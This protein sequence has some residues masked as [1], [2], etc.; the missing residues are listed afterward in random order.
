MKKKYCGIKTKDYKDIITSIG[1]VTPESQMKIDRQE[2][3]TVLNRGQNHLKEL[4]IQKWL[5][6]RKACNPF[7][8]F[9][10]ST[11]L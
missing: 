9:E 4:G 3:Y 6:L 10:V 2:I 7:L 5:S 1:S 11:N 8:S